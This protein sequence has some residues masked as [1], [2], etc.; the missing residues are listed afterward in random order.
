MGIG[1]RRPAGRRGAGFAVETRRAAVGDAGDAACVV[2]A[3]SPP[4]LRGA[5]DVWPG[6]PRRQPSSPPWTWG[7]P[8]SRSSC[9]A[10]A[11]THVPPRRSGLRLRRSGA[12]YGQARGLRAAVVHV[13]KAVSL[14]IHA[15]CR[16]DRPGPPSGSAIAIRAHRSARARA[17]PSPGMAG[18]RLVS[19]R[20]FPSPPPASRRPGARCSP[21]LVISRSISSGLTPLT[22]LCVDVRGHRTCVP[23]AP[24]L[25]IS[26]RWDGRLSVAGSPAGSRKNWFSKPELPASPVAK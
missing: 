1:H 13:V 7:R 16:R 24:H 2:V 18:M 6:P 17:S 11:T 3:G 4:G 20:P 12:K 9:V 26:A 8:P 19:A 22:R 23:A 5:D 10:R 25:L 15:R 14:R 21:S